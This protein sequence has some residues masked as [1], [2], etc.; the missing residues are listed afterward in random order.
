M[1][2]IQI[3]D[4]EKTMHKCYFLTHTFFLI[5]NFHQ[6]IIIFIKLSPYYR[7]VSESSYN[8]IKSSNDGLEI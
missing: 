6:K 2:N 5:R 7:V 3:Q 8:N 4:S 1:G